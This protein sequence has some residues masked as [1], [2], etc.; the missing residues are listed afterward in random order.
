MRVWEI[1]MSSPGEKRPI[2]MLDISRQNM[3]EHG[4]RDTEPSQDSP[5][6]WKRKGWMLA[7]LHITSLHAIIHHKIMILPRI[8]RK[9]KIN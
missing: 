4:P 1:G 6:R 8:T 2:A 3:I 5:W 9:L 7:N